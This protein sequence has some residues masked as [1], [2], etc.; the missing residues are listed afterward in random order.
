MSISVVF[1]C[2]GNICRSPA[3]DAYMR[4]KVAQENL[5]IKVDSAGTSA[6]HIGDKPHRTMISIG[7]TRGYNLNILRARQAK[8]KDFGEFDYIIAMDEQNFSDLEAIRPKDSKAKLVKLLDFSSLSLNSVPDPYYGGKEGFISCFDICE[9]GVNGF[10][11]H[12]K[13][14]K[15]I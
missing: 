13:I 10:L 15:V 7:E 6:Y 9:Q 8:S 14:E 12:L 2:L 5:N 4:F 3:A 1:V 11:E